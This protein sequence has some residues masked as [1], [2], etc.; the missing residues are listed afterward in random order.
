MV[1]RQFWFSFLCFRALKTHEILEILESEDIQGRDVAVYITPPDNVNSD[2]DE[3]SGDEEDF[4]PNRFNKNQLNCEGIL[5][6]DGVPF[7]GDVPV[8][9]SPEP[10]VPDSPDTPAGPSTSSENRTNKSSRRS[11]NNSVPSSKFSTVESL[12]YDSL[13]WS[14]SAIKQPVN[15]Y[16]EYPKYLPVSVCG[17]SHPL[18]YFQM[19]ITENFVEYI[20]RE[21]VSY[22][23]SKNDFDFSL[24]A[25][26]L[27]C[28]FG[29]LYLSG[30]VPLPRKRMFWEDSADVHNELVTNA[31]RRKRFEEIFKYLHFAD[32]SKLDKHDKM[33]K[34]RP[35]MDRLNDLFQKN[36]PPET[37]VSIDES[38]IPYFGR[39]NL[40][41]CIRNKP[42]RFGYK[43]WVM[44]HR[45][46]Y[47]VTF[48]IYQ[49]R[50]EKVSHTA[51]LG[52]SVVCS[53]AKVLKEQY[54]NMSFSLYFDNFFTTIPLMTYLAEQNFGATGTIRE[55]R[56][57]NCPL[58]NTQEMKKKKYAR[59]TFDFKGSDVVEAV[60]W[61]DNAVVTVITNEHST[62]PLNSTKRYSRDMKMVIEVPQPNVISKY[63]ANMG[64]VDILDSNVSN[65]RISMRSKKWYMPIFLWQLDIAMTNA[66]Q[67]SKTYGSTLDQLAFRRE[68]VISLLKLYGSVR[69]KPGPK[70]MCLHTPVPLR[71]DHKGHMIIS[72]QTRRRCALCKNKTVKAC[73]RCDV[74]L[75][76]KCFEEFHNSQ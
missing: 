29:I 41:Q 12:P 70:N 5:E 65:Y 11:R 61:K 31:M 71:H 2:T 1:S 68:V 76:D 25:P 20:V 33:A 10:V 4:D 63:N 38:M 39:H 7:E 75:H 23:A 56:L 50:S 22:A 16:S 60:K 54:P 37:V 17:E 24:S 34:L 13:E 58:M 47:C 57:K 8:T 35:V 6:M 52:E 43:A 48:D 69:S 66:W 15:I 18:H 40:K 55:N 53:F 67:L 73:R 44:S 49:G 30:Y 21:S 46:G 27:F 3:D 62:Y 74:A 9:P 19:F 36:A 32:N 45:L 42:V 28:F 64:G 14:E 26:E 59:G 72:G 51:C